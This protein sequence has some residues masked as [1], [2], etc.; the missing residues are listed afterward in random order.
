MSCSS[1]Q[2]PR[3]TDGARLSPH[4]ESLG[5]RSS[6]AVCMSTEKTQKF[7]K[8]YFFEYVMN[9][10]LA[11]WLAAR[12]KKSQSWEWGFFQPALIR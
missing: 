1:P 6:C 12:G 8:K 5:K 11:S 10:K 7:L 9:G 4:R 3:A 2:R